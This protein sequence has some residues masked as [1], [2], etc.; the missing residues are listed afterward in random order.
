MDEQIRAL[1]KRRRLQILVHSIIY[2]RF[3]DNIIDDYT[4]GTWALELEELQAKYP[5]IAESCPYADAFR[6]FDHSTGQN[7]PLDDEWG[8]SKALYLIRINRKLSK[9]KARKEDASLNTETPF[10]YPYQ[11]D[12]VGKMH[13]GCILNGGVGSGKSRTS[14]YYYWKL[15][16]GCEDPRLSTDDISSF[17]PLYIITTAKKR[18]SYEWEDELAA[19]NL[20][21]N[22][23]VIDSWNNIKKYETVRNAFFIFDEQRVVGYGA[24]S[25]T[26]IKIAKANEWILLSATPGDTWSDYI[27]VF[28]ANGFYKNKTDFYNQHVIWNHRCTFPKIER[29]I[30]TQHLMYL[31]SRLLVDMDFKRSAIAHHIDIHCEY[32]KSLYKETIKKRWDPYNNKPIEQASGLCY[33]LRRICN[34]D[35]RRLQTA[36]D[37]IRKH[38]KAVVFYNFDYELMDLRKAMTDNDIPF[39]EWNGHKHESV[40]DGEQWAY[41]VQYAAGAEGWN[42]IRTDTTIFYSLSYSYKIMAQAAGRIDRANTPYSDLFYYYLKSY[43]SI[44]LAIAKAIDGKRRFNE[45]TWVVW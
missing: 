15:N 28:I 40:P 33:V 39:T 27:P 41:L 8:V 44:D 17:K 10:L 11:S 24:W 12:A 29:Y 37:L 9:E 21:S 18:D 36:V 14:L 22:F 32:D 26:F 7:L 3:N 35:T 38:S 25:K 45:S 4:W 6:D 2:Y 20:P 30:E 16:G 31:R 23:A 42:C 19:Y 34:S 1:I 43:A 5:E 13:N